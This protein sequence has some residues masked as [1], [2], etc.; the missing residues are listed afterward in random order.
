MSRKPVITDTTNLLDRTN[1]DNKECAGIKFT[2]KDNLTKLWGVM[3]PTSGHGA[4]MNMQMKIA[5]AA[6]TVVGTGSIQSEQALS[7]AGRSVAFFFDSPVTLTSGTAYRVFLM[8]PND[9]VDDI[10]LSHIELSASTDQTKYF[11]MDDGEFAL[12]TATDPPEYGASGSGTWTDTST[13]LVPAQLIFLDEVPAISGGA[14]AL[15][16]S[17]H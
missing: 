1:V 6:G 15:T 13:E 11:G 3:W 9:T 16:G 4:D 8:N 12:T 14:S 7:Q 2:A 5:T 17:A 10:W